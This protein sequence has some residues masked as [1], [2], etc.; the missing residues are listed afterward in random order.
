MYYQSRNEDFFS[1]PRPSLL[2]SQDLMPHRDEMASMETNINPQSALS[3]PHQLRF[4]KINQIIVKEGRNSKSCSEAVPVTY[5]ICPRFKSTHSKQMNTVRVIR[6]YLQYNTQLHFIDAAS[7]LESTSF[8]TP[9]CWANKPDIVQ[10]SLQSSRKIPE[11]TQ[12]SMKALRADQYNI[13]EESSLFP[14]SDSA[15]MPPR[16]KRHRHEIWARSSK[17]MRHRWCE[18]RFLFLKKCRWRSVFQ[19][20]ERKSCCCLEDQW[21]LQSS[22]DLWKPKH[23]RREIAMC[24]DLIDSAC[25]NFPGPL[26]NFLY[27]H[28]GISNTASKPS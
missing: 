28:F 3:L 2:R 27:I 9:S 8:Q 5:K 12:T 20:I 21:V 23:E 16:S 7:K 26:N 13:I 11:R 4:G 6:S 1:S 17:I 19:C 18:G 15:D 22:R 25:K 10:G 14:S 24:H